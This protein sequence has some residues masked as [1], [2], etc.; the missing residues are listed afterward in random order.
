MTKDEIV[1]ILKS[2][3]DLKKNVFVCGNGGSAANAEHFSNDLFSKGVRA[4]C[5][6]SNTSIMTMIAND[7]GYDRVFSKQLEVYANEGDL[8]IMISC[9]GTSKNIVEVL[10]ID[11]EKIEIF[12]G[13]GT[14]GDKESA[15]Q[16]LLHQISEAL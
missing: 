13:H 14:Y 9:S 4:H 12:G 7:F 5:L 1:E 16:T 11:I 3:R 2:K 10:K 15:H 8:V 6:N